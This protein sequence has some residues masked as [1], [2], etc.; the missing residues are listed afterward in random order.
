MGS[1]VLLVEILLGHGVSGVADFDLAVGG[2]GDVGVGDC[3][4]VE[5]DAGVGSVGRLLDGGFGEGEAAWGLGVSVDVL[6]SSSG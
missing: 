2:F 5:C 6:S 3:V 1:L 4:G